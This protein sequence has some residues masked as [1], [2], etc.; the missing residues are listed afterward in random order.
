MSLLDV[1]F[2]NRMK[3][4]KLYYEWI[5][6]NGIADKPNS[7]VVFMHC[8][9]WLNEEKIGDDLRKNCKKGIEE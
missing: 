4:E 3:I 5:K 7:L 6:E 9:G 1:N 8:K 2:S